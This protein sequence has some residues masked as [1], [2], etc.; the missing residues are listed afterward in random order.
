M[1]T[2]SFFSGDVAK[3]MDRYGKTKRQQAVRQV[4]RGTTAAAVG[5]RSGGQAA[6]DYLRS[7]PSTNYGRDRA[8]FM[9]SLKAAEPYTTLAV[10]RE[11]YVRQN[12]TNRLIAELEAQ[13]AAM[14]AK[15]DV[16]IANARL[17][18]AQI[19]RELARKMENERRALEASQQGYG[20][21]ANTIGTFLQ[22][23]QTAAGRL[24]TQGL[25]RTM[26]AAGNV[27]VRGPG[28]AI[29]G[30]AG[31]AGGTWAEAALENAFA[32]LTADRA[33]EDSTPLAVVTVNGQPQEATAVAQTGLRKQAAL[34]LVVEA[35][36]DQGVDLTDPDTRAAFLQNASII[37]KAKGHFPEPFTEEDLQAAEN[38]VVR[39]TATSIEDL[40]INMPMRLNMEQAANAADAAERASRSASSRARLAAT[41]QQ[42]AE[43]LSMPT[44]ELQALGLEPGL[45]QD[46]LRAKASTERRGMETVQQGLLDASVA[47]SEE[48]LFNATLAAQYVAEAT[49]QDPTAVF[50]SA[51]QNMMNAGSLPPEVRAQ[52]V[53]E[54]GAFSPQRAAALQTASVQGQ[55]ARVRDTARNVETLAQEAA[56]AGV[57][58]GGLLESAADVR[59]MSDSDLTGGGGGGRPA[60]AVESYQQSQQD[61]EA[62]AT[63]AVQEQQRSAEDLQA[64]GKATVFGLEVDA[65]DVPQDLGG[66]LDLTLD[67]IE[68]YPQHPPLMQMKMDMMANPEF[69]K[70]QQAR[71]YTGEPDDWMWREFNREYKISKKM[72][73]RRNKARKRVGIRAGTVPGDVDLGDVKGPD[74]KDTDILT[75]RTAREYGRDLRGQK[76]DIMQAKKAQDAAERAVG[77]EAGSIGAGIRRRSSGPGP[78]VRRALPKGPLDL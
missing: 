45:L 32:L 10:S 44:S 2:P 39:T 64:R 50:S 56:G 60:S 21:S 16:S 7:Q 53:D 37:A 4:A 5:A 40:P 18:D 3:T 51:L 41:E 26:G 6:I 61:A 77:R 31:S 58:T 15:A 43:L 68:Q 48:Q 46:I 23:N 65:A 25:N 71:G 28:G 27:A 62:A 59:S 78:S 73:K 29:L 42:Y 76:R 12:K 8:L 49:G 69:Q 22:S 9:E 67:L 66:K 1:A 75:R 13:T 11:Q 72:N 14:R 63:A 38:T 54:A 57:D 52:V 17:K 19:Q 20:K 24:R 33:A 30:Y 74:V 34:S 70:W 35:A 47:T 36:K 55:Q